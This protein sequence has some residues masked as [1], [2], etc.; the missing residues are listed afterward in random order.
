[1]DQM[2]GTYSCKHVTNRWPLAMFLNMINIAVFTSFIIYDEINPVRQ[3]THNVLAQNTKCY[4]RAFDV[5]V[6]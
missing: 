2:L 1:M 3:S 4:G 5:M 6:S